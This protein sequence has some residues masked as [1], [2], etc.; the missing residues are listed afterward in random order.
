MQEVVD[1][2][3]LVADPHV[4]GRL[5]DGLVEQHEVCHED[6]VHT[7]ERIEGVEFVL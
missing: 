5:L 4:V 3:G 2:P 7:A 1:F 6:L